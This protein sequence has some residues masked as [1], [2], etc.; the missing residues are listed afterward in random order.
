MEHGKLQE[1]TGRSWAS[2][3]RRGNRYSSAAY[4][5][6]PQ[7]L[8]RVLGMKIFM[9]APARARCKPKRRDAI[10]EEV[11]PRELRNRRMIFYVG[12][13]LSLKGVDS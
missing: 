13:L 4:S 2:D 6:L 12:R 3:E 8:T 9:L 5:K 11:I 10:I 1:S 7:C